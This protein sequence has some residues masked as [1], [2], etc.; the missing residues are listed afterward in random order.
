MI[1]ITVPGKANYTGDD[2][3]HTISLLSFVEK[4][5]KKLLTRNIWGQSMGHV[6]YIYYHLPTNQELHR[7]CNASCDYTYTGWSGKQEVTLQL[8]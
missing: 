5:M 6:P 4:T 3:Y 7:N 1:F 8:S 2:G